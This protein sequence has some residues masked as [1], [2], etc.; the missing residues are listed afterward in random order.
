MLGQMRK[1]SESW[2]IKVIFAVIV[3]VFI[4]FFGYSRMQKG[5]G[6]KTGIAARVNGEAIPYGRYRIAFENA[7]EFYKKIFPDQMSDEM[8]FQIRASALSQVINEILLK[9][10]AEDM[11]I[12]VTVK[13]I[14][15][16]IASNPNFQNEGVFD[17]NAYKNV[18]LP[19]FERRYG[20]NYEKLLKD[21]LLADHARDF[22][23]NN[24][25][26]TENEAKETFYKEKTNWSFE[27]I[28]IP[29]SIAEDGKF[30]VDGQTIA[31]QVLESVKS[32][33][34][35]EL[36]SLVKKYSLKDEEIKDVTIDKK[37]RLLPDE[38]ENEFYLDIFS[39][40]KEKPTLAEP[41]KTGSSYYVFKLIDTKKPSDEDWEKQKEEYVKTLAEKK[42]QEYLMQWQETLKEKADIKEYILS[43]GN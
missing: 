28:I 5:S 7:S 3:L 40:N 31:S 14:Y 8:I 19:Y 24:V 42:K 12:K 4:F 11:G 30:D 6:G 21:G 1:H 43:T 20:L 18:F 32:G 26:I 34:K 17:S 41:L 33:S 22:I 16:T 27:R 15:D 29:E 23:L 9:Q 35:N 2:L 38:D 10:F 25:E 39:L 36:N 37:Q 13:E